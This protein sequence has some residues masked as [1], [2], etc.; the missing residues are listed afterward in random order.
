MSRRSCNVKGER[1]GLILELRE[2]LDL[3]LPTEVPDALSD[4]N[5]L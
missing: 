1:E 4:K 3:V 2:T 5:S